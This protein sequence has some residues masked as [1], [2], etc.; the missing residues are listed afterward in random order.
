M[1]VPNWT[2]PS[3]SKGG[4]KSVQASPDVMRNMVMSDRSNTPKYSGF[5]SLKKVTPMIAS[6]PRRPPAGRRVSRRDGKGRPR[7]RAPPGW[8][9]A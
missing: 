5:A 4:M 8:V 9:G 3:S 1:H 2:V 6:A 7:A